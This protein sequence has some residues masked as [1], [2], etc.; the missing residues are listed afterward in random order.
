M[1]RGGPGRPQAVC[2]PSPGASAAAR[3]GEQAVRD[4]S[5]G[6]Q[7]AAWQRGPGHPH[8]AGL[9]A[10]L[11]EAVQVGEP[12]ALHPLHAQHAW[13]AQRGEGG[14]RRHVGAARHALCQARRVGRLV[15]EVQLVLQ[16]P[17]A[18]GVGWGE[19]GGWACGEGWG[20]GR[21]MRHLARVLPG[22]APAIGLAAVRRGGAASGV[23]LPHEEKGQPVP[24]EAARSGAN[25]DWHS[26]RERA[27]AHGATRLPP[28]AA[29]A[30]G[31]CAC[32][33]TTA[34]P[35]PPTPLLQLLEEP[36]PG[37]GGEEAMPRVC[38]HQHGRQ[39]SFHRGAQ[40]RVLQA[41]GARP[42]LYAA[43]SAQSATPHAGVAGQAGRPCSA[44]ASRTGLGGADATPRRTAL[45]PARA[46][47]AAQ[48]WG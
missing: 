7:Q 38:Q 28:E 9:Q 39:V 14:R 16:L 12:A 29:R 32:P 40:T 18:R 4:P 34:C 11:Y 15:P 27:R 23:T 25:M 33:Q 20:G 3:M 8:L 5:R 44:D 46:S 2:P 36:A 37:G 22:V 19:V 21:Q 24:Q 35:P 45:L 13:R 10:L 6:A 41:H 43:P 1:R 48:P 31:G 42:R 17:A 47:G 26:T 30:G